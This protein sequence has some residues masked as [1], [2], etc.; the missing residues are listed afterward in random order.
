M[1]APPLPPFPSTNE[2]AANSKKDPLPPLEFTEAEM[3]LVRKWVT[4]YNKVQTT[5]D[6]HH[7]LITKVLPRLF[8]LNPDIRD[9][10]WKVRKAVSRPLLSLHRRSDPVN[11][12]QVK[13]W[14]QNQSRISS[15]TTRLSLKRN[16]S[17]KQVAC[18]IY[19][20]EIA[21]IVSKRANGAKAGTPQFM[22]NFQGAVQEFMAEL[23]EERLLALENE[24]ADW[25]NNGQPTEVKRKTAERMGHTYLE[26]SAQVQYKEMGMRSI[27][28]EFHQNKAGMK[29]FQA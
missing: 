25:Q 23:D 27:V 16:V 8:L 12:Q 5:K 2:A 29:L 6:R 19:K 9:N 24:R 26:K 14:F 1:S 28:L 22:A 13:R 10:E 17:L 11:L 15:A 21:A 7:M 20:A 18:K 3:H 4:L